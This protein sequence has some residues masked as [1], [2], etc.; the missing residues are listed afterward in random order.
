MLAINLALQNHEVRRK[1]CRERGEALE[2]LIIQG[3]VDTLVLHAAMRLRTG[4]PNYDLYEK[5]AELAKHILTL[6]DMVR[7]A[8]AL[9]SRSGFER[10]VE[11]TTDI[12]KK[13][14]TVD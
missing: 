7:R 11:K 4:K 12:L 13:Y 10:S 9:G 6:Q 3:V 2:K 8:R 1:W 14:Y 5:E